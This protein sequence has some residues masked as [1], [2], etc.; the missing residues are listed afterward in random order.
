[1][2]NQVIGVIVISSIVCYMFFLMYKT[3]KENRKFYQKE[4]E[5]EKRLTTELLKRTEIK[6]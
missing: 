3:E 6:L 5:K 4:Y 1:M 2:E